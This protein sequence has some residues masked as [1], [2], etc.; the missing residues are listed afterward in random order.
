MKIL[1]RLTA[2]VDQL[3][4]RFRRLQAENDTLRE[5]IQTMRSTI[6]S[7]EEK[8]SSLT[9]ALAQEEAVR[10]KALN[11]IDMLLQR[12]QDFDRVE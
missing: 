4:E 10:T 9:D 5:T 11:H 6:R 1:E 8:N 2:Q 3:L 12:I 7:L